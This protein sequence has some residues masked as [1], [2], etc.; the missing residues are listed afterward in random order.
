ME[1]IFKSIQESI[2]E[3]NLEAELRSMADKI[4]GPA[5]KMG[6]VGARPL[7]K[8]YYVLKDGDL[9]SSEKVKVYAALLYVIVPGDLIPRR[10]FGMLGIA[11]DMAAMAYA[12]KTIAKKI[13][14]IIDQKVEMK[15]DEWFGYEIVK[16]ENL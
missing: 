8:L 14:P 11:D 12:L 4:K 7:L 6:R 1:D 3:V 16:P 5:M 2:R 9:T 13:T 15:L 10:I